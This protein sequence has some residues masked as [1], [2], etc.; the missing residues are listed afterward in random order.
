LAEEL[1]QICEMVKW[2]EMELTKLTFE[3]I[4]LRN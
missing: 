4:W 3:T 1:Q 2:K